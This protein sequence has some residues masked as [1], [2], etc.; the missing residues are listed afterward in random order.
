[1]FWIVLLYIACMALNVLLT[2]FMPITNTDERVTFILCGFFTS[3]L[4]IIVC[5]VNLI[6]YI[7]N[8]ISFSHNCKKT[9]FLIEQFN[10]VI[11]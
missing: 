3:V 2:K 9:T 4:G 10:K 7:K 11:G 6:S 5:I 1:M 8:G